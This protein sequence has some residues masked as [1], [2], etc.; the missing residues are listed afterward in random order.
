MMSGAP[1]AMAI[2]ALGH[3]DQSFLIAAGL[4]VASS[5]PLGARGCLP[6]WLHFL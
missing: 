4:L 3:G 2:L 1:V 6:G 5:M